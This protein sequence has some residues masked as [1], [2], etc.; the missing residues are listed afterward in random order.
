[1]IHLCVHIKVKF[2]QNFIDFRSF[3]AV[4]IGLFLSIIYELMMN[5]LYSIDQDKRLY[6]QGYLQ[7]PFISNLSIYRTCNNQKY[8]SNYIGYKVSQ[9]PA[10]LDPSS[11]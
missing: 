8:H 11:V 4:N 9:V 7:N 10:H 1:M 2:I 6:D 3:L 5:T